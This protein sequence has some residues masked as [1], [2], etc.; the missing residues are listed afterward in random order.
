MRASIALALAALATSALAQNSTPGAAPER[1]AP[2]AKPGPCTPVG[3]T[4]ALTFSPGA[5]TVNTF[6]STADPELRK[7]IVYVPSTYSTQHARYPLVYMLHGTGQTAQIAMNNTTWNHAAEVGQFIAVYPQAL[8]Y[9]LLDGTTQTKWRTDSV[10][11]YVVDPS[12]LPMADD[13]QY[14]RELHNTLIANLHVDCAR[15]YA[16]GFS[17]GGG[18]VKQEL[19]VA[20]ADVFA[21]TSSAG[22]IG[23]SGGLPADYFPANG[24]DFRPHFEIVGTRDDRKIDNCIAAGDLLPGENLPRA[25]AAVIATPCMWNPLQVFAEGVGLDPALY[26]TLE[27]AA[28]TQFLWSSVVLPGPG[29]TEYRFRILPNLTH[30]YPSGTNYPTDYVPILWSWMKQFER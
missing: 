8:P 20:L 11:A 3:A 26:S 13:V 5:A 18:F 9:L 29:P 22:G 1:V 7:F 28:F 21:A 25:V 24:V 12:E 15:V 23:A 14:V 19:R 10:E 4:H 30:E 2:V 27:N 6:V 16:S 17:N